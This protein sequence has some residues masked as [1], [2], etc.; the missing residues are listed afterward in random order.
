M[1]QLVVTPERFPIRGSFTIARGSKS[2][3][4]VVLV[5]LHEDGLVGRGECV[6]YARY[7]E[8]VEDVAAALTALAAP[9]AAGMGREKLSSL[10]PPGAARNAIDCAF[11]D[12]EAKRTGTPAYELAGL[13]APQPA[14]TA[15]TISLDTPEAMA[16]AA[17]ASGHELLKLKLGTDGDPERIAA[18]RAAT[19]GTRLIV[20]ANEGWTAANLASN[21]AACADAG[22]ELVEQ[23]LPAAEDALLA[24]T[25]RPVPVCADESAHGLDSL[26]QLVGRY[27]ALNIKLDKTGGLTEALALA[28]AARAAGLDIMV[29]CMVATSLAMAPA[30]LLAPLA[31][32]VDLDGP[33][34]LARDREPSL[35][36]EGSV[37][38]PPEPALWG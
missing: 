38:Y 28:R 20:D 27:D 4:A 22:I 29:G 10:L 7:G 1:A 5:E 25:A 35:R 12:L 15:F 34:L 11:W 21:L 31:R 2:E 14:I 24:Y 33:L 26:P 18:V 9:V 19:P 6:P 36:Y 32:F 23:P 37:V 8:S 3:A 13:P 16:E 17:R 30:M